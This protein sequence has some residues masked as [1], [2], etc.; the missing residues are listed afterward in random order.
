M[1]GMLARK[2]SIAGLQG[3]S[4]V[5]V[6]VALFLQAF[7]MLGITALQV[8]AL[9]ST[10]ATLIDSQVQYL[11]AE[12]AERIRANPAAVYD[13]TFTD[14]TPPAFKDC[15][16]SLCSDSELARWD[17]EQWRNKIEDTNYLPEGES[18]VVFDSATQ[19]YDIAIH[20][21]WG[22]TAAQRVATRHCRRAHFAGS[23]DQVS[24]GQY[25]GAW[26]TYLGI[27][28]A[29]FLSRA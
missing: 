8:K 28:R 18:Q 4:L 19:R 17:V 24:G 12:M 14:E 21:T 11:L 25:P 27:H 9:K 10:Q 22:A 26:R 3:F 16:V 20:Y 13:I 23:T 7:G 1:A 15:N 5:E 2:I 29:R 6:L